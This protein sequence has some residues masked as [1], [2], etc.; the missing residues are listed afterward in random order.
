MVQHKQMWV[1]KGTV[2]WIKFGSLRN[3]YDSIENVFLFFQTLLQL[4]RLV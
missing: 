4:F 1:N 2:S 3:H